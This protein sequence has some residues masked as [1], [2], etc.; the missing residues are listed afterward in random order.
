MGSEPIWAVL[1]GITIGHDT[2]T[3]PGIAGAALIITGLH[4]SHTMAEAMLMRTSGM[5]PGDRL[6]APLPYADPRISLQ[7]PASRC[8][9]DL[10]Y[11]VCHLSEPLPGKA[12]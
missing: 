12:D 6:Q 4:L 9:T 1:I 2:L 10:R 5:R 8:G 7:T 11:A 3:L